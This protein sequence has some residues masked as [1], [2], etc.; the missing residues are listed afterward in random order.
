MLVDGMVIGVKNVTDG[1]AKS[2]IDELKNVMFELVKHVATAMAKKLKEYKAD[3]LPG[4]I[5]WNADESVQEILRSL[6]PTNDAS[7]SILGLN[8][9]LFKQNCNYKQRTLST[10]VEVMKNST[11]TWFSEQTQEMRDR[12]ITLARR[13]KKDVVLKDK[14][15]LE[16]QR[17]ARIELKRHEVEKSIRKNEK[18]RKER[19]RLNA[20]T[21][22]N[23]VAELHEELIKIQ[24][25][26]P[27]KTEMAELYFLRDQIARKTQKKVPLTIKGKRRS[28]TELKEE[29]TQLIEGLQ[30]KSYLKKRIQHRLIA[31]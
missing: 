6:P 31:K 1:S 15:E 23:S 21:P 20:I 26:T 17:Q 19:E 27:K 24:R 16:K 14:Q 13:R 22:I 3:Q 29:L 5:F 25:S 2:A 9:W 10:M 7:E 30:M 12:I 28:T 18:A 8:D 4:G 11:M